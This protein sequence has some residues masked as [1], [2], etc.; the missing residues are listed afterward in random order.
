MNCQRISNVVKDS[1]QE[2]NRCVNTSS[3]LLKRVACAALPF[4]SLYKPF[5]YTTSLIG[6]CLRLGCSISYLFSLDDPKKAPGA[7]LDLAVAVAS[8]FCTIIVHPL[9]M[10]VAASY[11]MGCQVKLLFVALQNKDTKKALE[12]ILHIS[13]N[14]VYLAALGTGTIQ[15]MALAVALQLLTGLYHGISEWKKG[16]YIE[17]LSHFAMAAVRGNHLASQLETQAS[18]RSA[19]SSVSSNVT[20]LRR[21][22]VSENYVGELGKKWQYPS[23]HLPVGMK[24]GDQRVLSWNILNKKFMSWVYSN[25]QGLN[26]SMLT[27][28]DKP[29]VSN[30]RITRRDE[31]VIAYILEMIGDTNSQGS[32]LFALQE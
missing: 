21:Q 6:S 11:D 16:N 32:F 10:V 18:Q 31:L 25:S 29:S 20:T 30:P 19:S 28:L 26:G 4:F 23:D 12:A 27:D 7:L 15:L 9:G 13:S 17:C 5:S 14:A 22:N 24:I 1:S 8:V 2:S 3:S